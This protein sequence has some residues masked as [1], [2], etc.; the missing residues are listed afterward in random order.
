MCNK[1]KVLPSKFMKN[2][3]KRKEKYTRIILYWVQEDEKTFEIIFFSF[4]LFS[5]HTHTHTNIIHILIY[6]NHTYTHKQSKLIQLKNRQ[7]KKKEVLNKQNDDDDDDG[8]IMVIKSYDGPKKMAKLF[9]TI[10]ICDSIH[11]LLLAS[12]SFFFS[13]IVWWKKTSFFWFCFDNSIFVC[14]F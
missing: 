3:K 13:L 12:F 5:K 6:A 14:C 2:Q 10:G 7:T 1:N 4:L 9:T 8:K 11:W